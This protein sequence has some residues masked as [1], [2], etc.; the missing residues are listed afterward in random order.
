MIFKGVVSSNYISIDTLK[1]YYTTQFKI[2]TDIK[3]VPNGEIVVKLLESSLSR[4]QIGET[5]IIHGYINRKL[6]I[7]AVL[8]ERVP[9]Y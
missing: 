9:L 2:F 3:T 6:E 4:P 5:L 8:I 1:G 7:E